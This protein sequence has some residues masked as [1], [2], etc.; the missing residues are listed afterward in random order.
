MDNLRAEG[1]YLKRGDRIG[2]SRPRIPAVHRDARRQTPRRRPTRVEPLLVA[3]PSSLQR[4][5]ARA[6]GTHLRRDG[7]SRKA[8]ERSAPRA[9]C[10]HL[11]ASTPGARRNQE[12][13][14]P[15]ARSSSWR[16]SA[17]PSSSRKHEPF[18][19]KPVD[20]TPGPFFAWLD[21]LSDRVL[22]R[23]EMRDRVPVRG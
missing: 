5:P 13:I 12:A 4:R 23:A 14:H 2:G 11:R 15:R 3:T 17:T 1:L 16:S 21:R 7:Q 6:E 19:P 22:S 10:D 8:R 18:E 9:N 20:V